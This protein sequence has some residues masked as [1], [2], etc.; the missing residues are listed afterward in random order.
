MVPYCMCAFIQV[1]VHDQALLFCV[2]CKDTCR[3]K[4]PLLTSRF[5]MNFFIGACFFQIV[6][7]TQMCIYRYQL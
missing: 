2:T 6:S 4:D 1:N 5:A 3:V 7:C